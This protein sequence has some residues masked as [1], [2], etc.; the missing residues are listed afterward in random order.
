MSG[1]PQLVRREPSIFCGAAVLLFVWSLGVTFLRLKGA[2]HM[3][4]REIR[5]PAP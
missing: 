1:L 4:R 2:S 3:P 5:W